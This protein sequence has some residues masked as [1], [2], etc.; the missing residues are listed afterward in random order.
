M[1]YTLPINILYANTKYA[2]PIMLLKHQFLTQYVCIYSTI[3]N[4]YLNLD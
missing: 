3:I 4:F 1:R 2:L